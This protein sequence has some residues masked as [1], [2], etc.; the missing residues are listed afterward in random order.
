MAARILRE[1]PPTEKQSE[2]IR[3]WL[4]KGA[5]PETAAAKAGID[6]GTFQRWLRAGAAGQPG[7]REF[8]EAVDAAL[9]EFECKLVDFLYANSNKNV[10][11]AQFL[12]NIRFGLKYKKAAEV[13]AGIFEA[14][15]NGIPKVAPTQEAV[16]AIEAK[17]L[18]ALDEEEAVH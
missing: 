18:A 6:K 12:L 1:Q 4:S 15:M 2:E 7:F 16:D 8:S 14:E 13:E 5:L 3:R 10:N 9:V 17:A 11:T